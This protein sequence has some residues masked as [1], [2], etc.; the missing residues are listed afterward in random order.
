MDKTQELI[1]LLKENPDR[2]LIF[3]YPEEH[4]EW[5]WT[6]GN[7]KRILFDEYIILNDRIWLKS[8][9]DEMYD[10]IFDNIALEIF[11]KLPLTDEQL[12]QVDLATKEFIKTRNWKKAIIVYIAPNF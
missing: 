4:S 6:V 9:E 2:E 12:E 3:L 1:E 5:Y 8:N 7:P 10:E 11:D